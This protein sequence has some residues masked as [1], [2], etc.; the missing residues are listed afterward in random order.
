MAPQLLADSRSSLSLGFDIVHKATGD[1]SF[2]FVPNLGS[3]RG[4]VLQW[5]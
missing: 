3:F 2:Q 4:H 5:G 1:N